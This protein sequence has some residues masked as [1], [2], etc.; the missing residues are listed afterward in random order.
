[1][2]HGC[3]SLVWLVVCLQACDDDETTPADTPDEGGQ[4]ADGA[5]PD[6]APL[7]EETAAQAIAASHT[8]ML[9]AVR[10]HLEA[11]EY[12]VDGEWQDHYG[13]APFYGPAFD[14]GHWAATGD[15]A[16]RTR[17]IA[18]LDHDLE[19]VETALAQPGMLLS[20]MESLS[21]ALLG[22]LEAGQYLD[23][24]RY[25]EVADEMVAFVDL[26]ADRFDNY[27]QVEI[28]EFAATTYGPTAVSSFLALM[29]VQ[30][31]FAH[32]D[33]EPELHLRRAVEV[34]EAVHEKA[35]DED[36]SAYRFAPEDERRM[37]YPNITMMLAYGRLFALTGEAEWLSR[38]EAIH[39]G[40]QP[41]RD[42]AGDHFHSPYSAEY[43]GANDDDY[44]TLSSQNYLMLALWTAHIATGDMKW[45]ADIDVVL[46]FYESHLLEDGR[47][48]HHWMNGRIAIPEDR[49]YYCTGCNLQALYVM[50][51]LS[52]EG[53]PPPPRE[54]PS[55]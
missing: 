6:A 5:V 10:E 27:L 36:L 2:R 23:E 52:R 41:L 55:E 49:E 13:D 7:P 16:Y 3:V 34:L 28:G 51:L 35:W 22:L 50:T 53:F 39:E 21:M 1:M 30:H 31:V 11:A 29:H 43:M 19:L 26:L 42:E 8:D 24:P 25:H 45:L 4:V 33:H 9:G 18:A 38:I 40:I 47:I 54:A 12:F 46:G 44:V 37:L 15:E 14:L 48:L 32:P 17:A 20:D